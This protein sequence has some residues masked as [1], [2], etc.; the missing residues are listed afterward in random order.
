MREG[1]G[2]LKVPQRDSL[3]AEMSNYSPSTAYSKSMN[4]LPL[5]KLFSGN[6][7]RLY[8]NDSGSYPQLGV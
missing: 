7:N 4:S 5:D 2:A 8:G 1:R 3:K 6:R